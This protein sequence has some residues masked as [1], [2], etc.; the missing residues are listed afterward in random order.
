MRIQTFVGKVGVESLKQ[1]DNHINVWLESHRIESKMVHQ[2]FGYERH[3][4]V[5]S[6]EPVIVTSV[7]Y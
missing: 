7:W 3:H 4:E 1:M 2:C 5:G 6:S